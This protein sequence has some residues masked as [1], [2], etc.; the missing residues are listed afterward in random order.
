MRRRLAV[1]VVVIACAVIGCEIEVPLV[2]TV[3]AGN[4][5]GGVLPDASLG[6][7]S[8]SGSGGGSGDAGVAA[9]SDGGSGGGLIDAALID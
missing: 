6:S 5:G 8:G 9:G 7:G 4:D 3:D 1:L 2:D